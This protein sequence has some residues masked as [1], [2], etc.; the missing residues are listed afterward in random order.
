V[1]YFVHGARR[2]R[3]ATDPNYSRDADT[4]AAEKRKLET[5]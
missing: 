3:L 4:T 2:S 5:S 1:V